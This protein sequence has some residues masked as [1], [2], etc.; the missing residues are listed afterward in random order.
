MTLFR[1]PPVDF[2]T[3]D[4]PSVEGQHT[5]DGTV[6]LQGSVSSE[7]TLR[8]GEVPP[9]ISTTEQRISAAPISNSEARHLNEV[10]DPKRYSVLGK[11]GAGG[12]AT[13]YL[14]RDQ[15]LLRS[16]ALKVQHAD[17]DGVSG[18][19]LEEAQVLGQLEHPN[20]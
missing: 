16:V 17:P 6:S 12:M 15:S 13:V 3:V 1:S 2:K 10:I 14:A 7:G 18:R 5:I 9:P 8:E 20:I 19:F 11:I 4:S